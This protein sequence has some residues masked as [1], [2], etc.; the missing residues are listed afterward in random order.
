MIVLRNVITGKELAISDKKGREIFGLTEGKASL[1]FLPASKF[2]PGRGICNIS[3]SK[4]EGKAKKIGGTCIIRMGGIG[5]LFILSSSLVKRKKKYPNNKITLA[6]LPQY[7]PLMKNLKGVD[8]CI[9]VDDVDTYSFNEVIDLRHAVEPSNVGPG[10]LSWKDYVSHDRSDNFDR[11]CGVNSTRKYFN[12]PVDNKFAFTKPKGLV[13]GIN[14]TSKSAIR[15]IPPEY[16]E[17]LTDMLIRRLGATVVL[18]GKTEHWNRDLTRING[19]KIINLLDT[20][21]ENDLITLTSRMDLVITPDTGALHIAAALKKK[22]L[23]LFGPIDPATRT[24]YYPTVKTIYPKGELSCIPCWDIPG[25][26]NNGHPGA[27]C[28]RLI[29]PEKIVKAVRGMIQ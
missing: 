4:I 26:C 14:P 27:D 22:C 7:I 6:T 9:S 2:V 8:F 16:V 13:I 29:T 20:T 11:L 18:M 12:A 3:I 23:G 1:V 15:V 19:N 5:D 17:P 28:M 25:C 10:K 21:S 24:A